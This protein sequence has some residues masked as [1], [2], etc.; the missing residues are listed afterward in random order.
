MNRR[1]L[2]QKALKAAL[3]LRRGAG[4]SLTAPI[5]AY[6][7]AEHLGVEVRFTDIASLEG[8]YIGR[9]PPLILVS[10]ARPPGRQ[11]FTCAHELGH[12]VFKH[13]IKAISI[14]P[15]V[16]S[17]REPAEYLADTFAG[18]LL[19]PKSAVRKAFATR[20]WSMERPTP[21][22]VYRVAT[23]LGVGYTALVTQMYRSLHAL[24]SCYAESLLSAKPRQIK[25]AIAR[26]PL[27]GNLVIVDYEWI[28]HA[29]DIVVGDLVASPFTILSNKP[30]FSSVHGSETWQMHEAVGP[31]ISEVRSEDGCWSGLIRIRQKGY[32]GRSIFRHLEEINGE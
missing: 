17:R 13:N 18:Y 26:K 16:G 31:G 14:T 25:A 9:E 27:L 21:E 22:Q 24:P 28:G 15:E 3:T 6:D 30:I 32:T 4:Y 5:C 19:M 10:C 23:W 29:V 11:M 1:H 12:H 7:L 8:M 2:A 20:G